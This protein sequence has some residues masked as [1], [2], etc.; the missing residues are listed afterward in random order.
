MSPKYQQPKTSTAKGGPVDFLS[1]LPTVAGSLPHGMAHKFEAVPLHDAE[2]LRLPPPKGRCRLT[3]LS[4]S[5]LIETAEAAKAVVR[6][7]LPGKTR[8]AVLVDRGRLVA[9]L[10]GLAGQ[11][12]ANSEQ[13]N[14]A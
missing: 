12:G 14:N 7:R 9:F 2:C 8:G 1:S 10:H 11:S 3:G 13:G 5:G 6:V 4:R